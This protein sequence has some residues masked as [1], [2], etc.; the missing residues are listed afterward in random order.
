MTYYSYFKS[1]SLFLTRVP[2]D[3]FCLQLTQILS[4]NIR[5]FDVSIEAGNFI[6]SAVAFITFTLHMT[7]LPLSLIALLMYWR[8]TILH[9]GG[10]TRDYLIL[11]EY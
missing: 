6:S 2:D 1:I 9:F 5:E 3:N 11:E 10:N 7:I 4:H 8:V